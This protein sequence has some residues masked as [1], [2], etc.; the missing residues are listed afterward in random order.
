MIIERSERLRMAP[1]RLNVAPHR[2]VS[3]VNV[4]LRAQRISPQP[5]FL[6]RHGTADADVMPMSPEA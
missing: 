4:R 5:E 3:D 1:R 6:S 2:L